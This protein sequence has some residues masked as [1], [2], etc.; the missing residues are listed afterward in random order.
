MKRPFMSRTL[1][2]T[3]SLSWRFPK[4]LAAENPWR[5]EARQSQDFGIYSNGS[6]PIRG[7]GGGRKTFYRKWQRDGIRTL[8]D[9][10]KQ[11]RLHPEPAKRSVSSPQGKPS[12]GRPVQRLDR[13][14][15]YRLRGAA[16]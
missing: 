12:P 14:G 1:T 13:L 16:G 6:I 15:K 11:L 3:P 7:C 10:C 9:A 4:R 5:T 2:A 8:L